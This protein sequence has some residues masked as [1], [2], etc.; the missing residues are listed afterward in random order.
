M[1]VLP[2]ESGSRREFFRGGARHVL[3]GLLAVAAGV[4]GRRMVL[5][6]QQCINRGICRGCATFEDC[7][8]PSALSAKQAQANQRGSA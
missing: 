4:L 6:G 3:T 1:R 7:G 2:G 8:L 5:P